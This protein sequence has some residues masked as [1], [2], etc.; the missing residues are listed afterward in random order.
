MEGSVRAVLARRALLLVHPDRRD[1]K[2]R[3]QH[4]LT[5]R[6]LRSLRATEVTGSARPLPPPLAYATVGENFLTYKPLPRPAHRD[7]RR[8]LRRHVFEFVTEA[9]HVRVYGADEGRAVVAPVVVRDGL[10]R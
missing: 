5:S 4:E 1:C 6:L 2:W 9:R 10:A 7:Q 3:G 8:R